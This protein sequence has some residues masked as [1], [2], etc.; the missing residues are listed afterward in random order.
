MKKINAS[1]IIAAQVLN[2]DF[3]ESRNSFVINCVSKQSDGGYK[4]HDPIWTNSSQTPLFVAGQ[5]VNLIPIKGKDGK[6][7]QQILPA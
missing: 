6:T 2:V 3:A 1:S 5:A 4:V 7:R